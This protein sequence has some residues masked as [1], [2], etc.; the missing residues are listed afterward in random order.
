[1]HECWNLETLSQDYQVFLDRFRPILRTLDGQTDLD[2]EQCF[3][4]RTLLIHHY[5]RL[6]LRDPR[7]PEKLLP[8]DWVGTSARILCRNI[9]RQIFQ[10]A[11]LYLSKTQET[12]D[13]PLPDPA[14]H[15][16]KRFGGL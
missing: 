12:A 2:P 7:L 14:P 3:Q 4:L 6:L 16:F 9:Y 15:F 13:G 11:E 1:M 8:A 10:P 5:R